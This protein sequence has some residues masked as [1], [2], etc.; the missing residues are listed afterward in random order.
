MIQKSKYNYVI[1]FLVL[2]G[3]LSCQPIISQLN[4]M[5][6][7]IKQTQNNYN[8]MT[9]LPPVS[10]NTGFGY[11]KFNISM[12]AI[13]DAL[14]YLK[15]YHKLQITSLPFSRINKVKIKITGTDNDFD[16]QKIVNLSVTGVEL[17]LQ[18]PL[19][20]NYIVTVQGLD[21]ITEIPGAEVKSY[22]S[23]TTA[24]TSQTI[25]INPKTTPIAKIIEGVKTK[26]TD[27][28]GM[29]ANLDTDALAKLVDDTRGVLYPTFINTDAF[30][31]A[32]V[33]KKGVIPSVAPSSARLD[34]GKITGSIEGL[35]PGDVAVLS[36]NDPSSQPKVIVAPPQVTATA[37]GGTSSSSSTAI[38]YTI[39][40]VSVGNWT[41]SVAASGYTIANAATTT[42]A[43]AEKP[44]MASI[45]IASGSSGAA[46]FTLTPVSWSS[47]PVNVSGNLGSSDEPDVAI[48]GVDNLHLVWRQDGFPDPASGWIY[49][50]RWNGT[51]WS[52][53]NRMIS[54]AGTENFRGA[55]HPSIDVST[56]RMPHVVW[57]SNNSAGVR[58]ILYAHFDGTKWIA[59]VAIS[60]DSYD[61][62]NLWTSDYPDIVINKING[63]IY[64]VWQ[65]YDAANSIY[66]IYFTEYDGSKWINPIRLGV[67][68]GRNN[69]MPK[70][71][72]GTD[73]VIH[74][75]WKSA[76][77]QKLKYCNF[78]GKN[79]ISEESVPMAIIGSDLNNSLDMRV[80]VLNRAHIVWRN[81]IY[82]QYIMRS[83]NSWGQPETANQVIGRDLTSTT[84]TGL[85]IDNI[86]NVDIVWGSIN[87]SSQPV[88][89]FRKRTN[90][91]WDSPASGTPTPTLTPYP[92]PSPVGSATATPTPSGSVSAT[93]KLGYEDLPYSQN[94]ASG[95]RPLII[96][97]TTGTIHV[98]WSN[99]GSDPV[100]SDIFHSMK[101]P[102]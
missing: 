36:C 37:S 46:D 52:R 72:V 17:N 50:S 49:Y 74:V 20:K 57:S 67:S 31:S 48:D 33:D 85:F 45:S 14:E 27:K 63:H 28:T 34:S 59:P 92:T 29:A 23:V 38:N 58:K 71:A 15:K 81:D 41:V 6:S 75:V 95:D 3:M 93:P 83:N 12:P 43:S 94:K 5:G 77:E 47:T 79:W 18:V 61:P 88:I 69:V 99:S 40:N 35:Q 8:D 10:F 21:D 25:E 26:D 9:K 84:E 54:P 62:N 66:N 87:A 97:E 30:V 82:I 68:N 19:G 16:E 80:D 98:I 102:I 22:F 90:E 42:S 101:G 65:K 70:V 44:N 55:L 13:K 96:V 1:W 100:N 24:N 32:I 53:D 4:N 56:D 7:Q 78:D 2:G 89:R 64:V 73:N 39:D 91:G 11:I 86:G 51:A 60:D 76:G